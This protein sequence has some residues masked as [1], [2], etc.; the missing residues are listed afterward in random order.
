MLSVVPAEHTAPRL[1]PLL[2][3]GLLLPG[4]CL[5]NGT[6]AQPQPVTPPP[7]AVTSLHGPSIAVQSK[8]PD[9]QWLDGLNHSIVNFLDDS[10]LWI[11]SHFSDDTVPA[12]GSVKEGSQPREE[13]EARAKVVFGW[14]P[15]N[16]DLTDMPLK[17]RVKVKLPNLKNSLKDTVDLIFSDNE[18]QEFNQLPLEST[19]PESVKTEASEFSAAIRLMHHTRGQSYHSTRL[20]IGR[21][22][23][24]ARSRYHWQRPLSERWQLSVE[25]AL[26]YYANDG[27]GARLL[28]ELTFNPHD[29]QQYRISYS[30]WHRE[31]LDDPEWKLGLY[32][33]TRLGEHTSVVNGVL[34]DGDFS[35]SH[36]DK[37]ITLSSRWRH[38]ALRD[39][40]FF[41][42]EPFIDFEREDNYD[43]KFGLAL[44]VGGY[45]GYDND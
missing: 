15:K 3:G 6:P 27:L 21:Q 5:A 31:D 33:I 12:D 2:L 45:F 37:K 17:F 7:A 34:V 24:Y 35:A 41:E 13:V 20:G 42:V 28:N 32:S 44:R 40:L 36:R 8:E 14:Q 39:W 4:V 11:D 30:V 9:Y 43:G 26:E 23:L 16:G 19:R 1:C 29:N 38:H 25:P 18:L 10:A 22:Q